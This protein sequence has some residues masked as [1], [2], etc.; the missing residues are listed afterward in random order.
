MIPPG[1][2]SK[3]LPVWFCSRSV[4]SRN[5]QAALMASEGLEKIYLMPATAI[6]ESGL[7]IVQQEKFLIK[8][9]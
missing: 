7:Q 8:C 6:S 5:A 3:Q 1:A 2:A 4:G 9:L